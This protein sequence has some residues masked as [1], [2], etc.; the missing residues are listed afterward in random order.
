M[1]LCPQHNT[2]WEKL[3][4]NE[5]LNLIGDIK[6]LNKEELKFLK[7]FLTRML[8]LEEYVDV[9]ATNLS[10]GNKRK[11]VCAMALICFP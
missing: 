9:L 7:G 8:E 11:L 1:G 10:G 2:I 5:S 6:G 3:T 4:V